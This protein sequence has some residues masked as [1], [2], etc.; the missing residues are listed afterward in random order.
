MSGRVTCGVEL[1]GDGVEVGAAGIFEAVAVSK[2]DDVE[3][4]G[5]CLREDEIY[6]DCGEIWLERSTRC[7]SCLAW[8]LRKR[9]L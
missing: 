5:E 4:D 7:G 6:C 2:S 1:A 9:F 3:P 8:K